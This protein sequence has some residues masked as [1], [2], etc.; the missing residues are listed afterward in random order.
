VI[1][2]ILAILLPVFLLG[3]LILF[4]LVIGRLFRPVP[5]TTDEHI[6]ADLMAALARMDQRIATLERILDA[7]EPKWRARL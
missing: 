2:P 7:D 5:T 4:A 6:V 1:I 3:G